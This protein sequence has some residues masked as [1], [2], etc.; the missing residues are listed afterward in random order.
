MMGGGGGW[1]LSADIVKKL[2]GGDMKGYR[3]AYE[4]FKKPHKE[5]S[6]GNRTLTY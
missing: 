6:Y 1:L 4:I 3:N 2:N 5:R